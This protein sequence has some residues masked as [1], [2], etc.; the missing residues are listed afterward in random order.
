MV[1]AIETNSSLPSYMN[2]EDSLYPNIPSSHTG[3]I[4]PSAAVA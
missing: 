1:H 3:S 2:C 4:H